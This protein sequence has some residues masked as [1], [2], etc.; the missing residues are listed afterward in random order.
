VKLQP[1]ESLAG[2]ILRKAPRRGGSGRVAR[3]GARMSTSLL[4]HAFARRGTPL[5]FSELAGAMAETGALVSELAA[6]LAMA[7]QERFIVSC[8]FAQ[9]DEST[10][11]GPRLLVLSA[12][13][14]A[15]VAADR[16]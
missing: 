9:A 1:T 7:L 13:G 12:R 2:P 15:A 8:G 11:L 6:A 3:K 16:V 14:R 10:S 5:T 4:L